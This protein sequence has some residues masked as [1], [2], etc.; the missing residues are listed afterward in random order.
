MTDNLLTNIKE[1]ETWCQAFGFIKTS[2]KANSGQEKKN[3]EHYIDVAT[4]L[5]CDTDSLKE[6]L[7]VDLKEL[8]T[9]M[10]NWIAK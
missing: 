6:W 3:Q 5:F 1:S 4:K 8:G 2:S 9:V 10:K 7:D